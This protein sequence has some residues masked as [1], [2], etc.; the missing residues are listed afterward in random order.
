MAPAR[1]LLHYR[2]RKKVPSRNVKALKE[3][4]NHKLLTY[5]EITLCKANFSTIK[6]PSGKIFRLRLQFRQQKVHAVSGNA[7][8]RVK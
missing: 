3:L 6:A 8:E 2:L 5:S 7:L 4:Q 1:Y